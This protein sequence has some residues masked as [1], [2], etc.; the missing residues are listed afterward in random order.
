MNSNDAVV[1]VWDESPY[2]SRQNKNEMERTNV[3][4]PRLHKPL[5]L[6]DAGW[7]VISAG[8]L[9]SGASPTPNAHIQ[10]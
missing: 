6:V 1:S 10:P 3:R 2:M 4:R 5:F 8:C 9:E 7:S